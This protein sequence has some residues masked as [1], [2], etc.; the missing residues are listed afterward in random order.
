MTDYDTK[1]CRKGSMVVFLQGQCYI[2]AC[3]SILQGWSIRMPHHDSTSWCRTGRDGAFGQDQHGA[4]GPGRQELDI[5]RV[6]HITCNIFEHGLQPNHHPRAPC[7]HARPCPFDTDIQLCLRCPYNP[8]FSFCVMQC[9][10]QLCWCDPT[11]HC[12]GE[13][14]FIELY[15]DFMLTT[16]SQAPV[17]TTPGKA[18]PSHNIARFVLADQSLEADLH[19]KHPWDPKQTHSISVSFGW[20]SKMSSRLVAKNIESD[21]LI[22]LGGCWGFEDGALLSMVPP[23]WPKGWKHMH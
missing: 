19:G 7:P 10:N 20:T 13:T 3:R 14:T 21:V 12:Q 1:H 23:S 15:V 17:N 5:F 6:C 8:V 4:F 2:N 22:R 9:A 11:C 16:N 18:R